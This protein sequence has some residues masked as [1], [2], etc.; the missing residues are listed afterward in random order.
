MLGEAATR[1]AEDKQTCY[2]ILL[3]R[4]QPP[5]AFQA[6]TFETLDNLNADALALL[7][8]PRDF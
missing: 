1:A 8:R 3:A 6:F 2:A 7:K 5:V 4:H